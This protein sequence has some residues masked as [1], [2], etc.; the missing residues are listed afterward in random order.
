MKYSKNEMKQ[1]LD[2]DNFK[3]KK[4]YG[5]NFIIDSN[6]VENIV[7]KSLVDKETLVIEIGPGAGSLTLKLVEKAGFVLCYEIDKEIENILNSNLQEYDNYRVIFD[8]FLKRN[9]KEDIKDYKYKKLYIISNLPYYI[10]TP[11]ILNIINQKINVDKMIFMVQKEVGNRFKALP[12]T[13]DYNSLTI[14]L[15]YYFNVQKI[16]DVSRNVFIPI[17]NVDSIVIEFTKKNKKVELVDEEIFFK[18]VR[19]SFSQKRKTI[20]NNLK[21]YNLELI[22]KVLNNF[23][24]NLATRAEQIPINV[25]IEIAN[26]LYNEQK[27]A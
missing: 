6:I 27:C 4:K 16:M 25:F 10:T 23:G 18:L 24:Y 22:N 8:D 3:F 1:I 7:K 15:N 5:Q 20:K 17:P 19:D 14:Y 2:K 21:G 26:S 12:G 9:V 11:I 13:K